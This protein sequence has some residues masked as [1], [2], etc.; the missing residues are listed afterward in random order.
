MARTILLV[1]L[2]GA[3]VCHAA[4]PR[5]AGVVFEGVTRYT[6]EAL[7]PLYRTD[8]GQPIDAA[9]RARIAH[10][11]RER[12]ET[13]GYVAPQVDDVEQD[14]TPGVLVFNV[15]EPAIRRVSVSGEQYVADARFW[16]DVTALQREK[17]L[18]KQTFQDWLGRVNRY[19]GMN[20]R[21]SLDEVPDS[22][23]YVAQVRIE[24]TRLTGMLHVDNRAPEVLGNE[25]IQA[26][27]AYRFAD[28]RAGT[29]FAGIAMA[30]D[31]DRLES[32]SV[33][34]S[35]AFDNS[36]DAFEW[37]YS[38]S[39][40]TLPVEDGIKDDYDRARVTAGLRAA[41]FADAAL[42]VDGWTRL[43]RYDVD[44]SDPDGVLVRRDRVRSIEVG[45]SLSANGSQ[46][47]RHDLTL[48]LIHGIDAFGAQASEPGGSTQP[49]L[50]YMRYVLS[51]RVAQQIGELWSATLG[52]E[53]QA[54]TDHLP[55]S[56]RFFI[57]GRQLG[58][59]FDPASVTGDQGVGARIE[60]ARYVV[61]P[62]FASPLQ[63]Y[64]YYD[65]GLTRSNDPNDPSDAASSIGTGVR[66]TLGRLSADLE[67]ATPIED[68]NSNPLA[69]NGTRVFFALTQ[70]FL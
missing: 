49:D 59:A 23:D 62:R 2:L 66:M 11:L 69:D 24:P 26:Q 37:S 50:D 44:E 67:V 64:A 10:G 9:M 27:A 68:P 43:A 3:G 14:A 63:T 12:Y 47:R 13:D 4:V 29:V 17:P 8:L 58:G 19:D 57:G 21:G 32:G 31:V 18:G 61:L 45:A 30:N 20:V 51:Y 41:L 22:A 53:G 70:R 42:R 39:K 1:M 54:S 34:G 52:V 40:S 55:V 16:Q 46:T 6:P 56:E 28:P 65:Y 48:S 15:R 35:H 7:L 60:V 5:L 38:R 33:G 25:I 36:G